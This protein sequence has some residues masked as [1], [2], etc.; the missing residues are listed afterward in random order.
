MTNAN[1]SIGWADPL[2]SFEEKKSN[3]YGLKIARMISSEWFNGGVISTGCEFMTRRD[4]IHN[5]RL[6][7]RGEQDVKPFKLHMKRGDNDLDF[8]NVDWTIINHV[9]KY[10]NNVSNGIKDDYYRLDIVPMDALSAK[11]KTDK[12]KQYRKDMVA[13]PLYEKAKQ[14]LGIDLMPQGFIPEDEDELQLWMQIKD[15][16]KMAIVE[17]I[18]IDW[19]K[20]ANNWSTFQTSKNKDL[21]NISM[22]GARVWIDKNEGVKFKYVDPANYIHSFVKNND[23]SDKFYEAEV[24]TI[25]LADLQR[26][27]GFSD[28]VMRFIAK[29]YCSAGRYIINNINSCTMDNILFHKVDILRFAYQTGKKDVYKMTT[30]Y[31][32]LVK[33]SKRSEDY[34]AQQKSSTRTLDTWMEGNYVI[35]TD[36]IYDY[37]ETENICRDGSG[38]ARSQFVMRAVDIYENRLR[39][40]LDDIK[41]IAN[42]LQK[43]SL[44]VQQLT[45]EVKPDLVRINVDQLADLGGKNKKENWKEVISLLN[46]KGVILEKTIDMGDEGGLQKGSPATTQSQQQGS[47]IVVLLNRYAQLERQLSDISG[48]NPSSALPSDTLV[49]VAKL[50]ELA[51]NTNTKHIVEASVELDLE[52][53]KAI[54]ARITEIFKSDDSE[55]IKEI[56]RNVVSKAGLDSLE[57][58]K[59]RSMSD[60]G[61]VFKMMPTKEEMD[62]FKGVL[63]LGV[64]EGTVDPETIIQVTPIA[65]VNYDLAIQ[66]LMYNRRRKIKMKQAQDMQNIQAQAKATQDA[67]MTKVQAET[68]AY[69]SKKMTD[70]QYET[71]MAKI[72][73]EEY[74]AI[75]QIDAP[76]EDKEFQQEVYI[77]KLDSYV[78]MENMKYGEDRKDSR[79]DSQATKQSVMINQRQKNTDPVDFEMEDNWMNQ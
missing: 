45:A 72:R 57:V 77:H 78:K 25:S 24:D 14:E 41:P 74:M 27:S 3:P 18:L 65:K 2:A 46:V 35:G 44:K 50:Q 55:H 58:L 30:R 10:C 51:S 33:M 63:Q 53:S 9:A 39:A 79:V 21:V 11:I 54:S 76:I 52:I 66:Y 36:Y 6:F 12:E 61:F 48:T 31:G 8:L 4:Y 64:S 42:E 16:P 20:A 7:V 69:K 28:A 19:I 15:R 43:I 71:Q 17:E 60:L 34:A 47:G 13:K 37:K 32:K 62:E 40:F 1:Y 5:N 70:L 56:Y 23:F 38:R 29:S 68:E 67:T 26:E 59:D 22:S 75:K 49:G 73:N